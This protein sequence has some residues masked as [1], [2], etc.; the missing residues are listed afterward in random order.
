MSGDSDTGTFELVRESDSIEF[1]RRLGASLRAGDLVLLDGP[2]GAGKTVVA[3]GIAAGMGVRGRVTSPTFVIARVHPSQG[4]DGPALVHADAYRLNHLDEID[5]LDLD[6]DLTDA[7]VVVE[8]G[9]G[10]V[11]RLA[12][13]YLVVR[14]RRRADDVREVTVE[15]HGR[16]WEPVMRSIVG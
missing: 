3:R 6:T 13:E 2:L 11:E 1:G 12:D 5:D 14:L 7:A 9:E 10:A 8:W 16:R 15:P 4:D